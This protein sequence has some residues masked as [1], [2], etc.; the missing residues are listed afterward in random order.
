MCRYASY[1]LCL[2]N[3]KRHMVVTTR[4]QSRK[5]AKASRS[6][7]H[8]AGYYHVGDRVQKPTAESVDAAR[9]LKQLW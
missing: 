6:V 7:P 3:K 5:K 8:H 1:I 2:M 9:F 4:S